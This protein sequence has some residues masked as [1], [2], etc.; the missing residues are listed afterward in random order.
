MNKET[1]SLVCGA[2]G[3]W[4][5]VRDLSSKTS[6]SLYKM[7]G[8]LTNDMLVV[9]LSHLTV[10]FFA[11]STSATFRIGVFLENLKNA[12]EGLFLANI[13]IL[14]SLFILR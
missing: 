6:N 7:K 8:Q 5:I 13:F 12:I 1:S 2:S 9:K 11:E 4:V 10:N 3:S 14:A